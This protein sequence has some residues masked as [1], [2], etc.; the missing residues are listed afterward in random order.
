MFLGSRPIW[1]D[2]ATNSLQEL[3]LAP[4][5]IVSRLPA[6]KH[7]RQ[8]FLHGHIPRQARDKV[9]IEHNQTKTYQPRARK[10]EVRILSRSARMVQD[11]CAAAC[12]SSF[13]FRIKYESPICTHLSVPAATYRSS[14][15]NQ[16]VHQF[17]RSKAIRCTEWIL[18]YGP[19]DSC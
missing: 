17:P 8:T 1:T 18:I 14:V 13:I 19:A 6:P 4:N 11:N 12:Y 16:A 9:T 15:Q 10:S 5:A 3:F 7:H 2:E